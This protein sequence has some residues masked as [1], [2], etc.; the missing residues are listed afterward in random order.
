MARPDWPE[1]RPIA[2][3]VAAWLALAGWKLVLPGIAFAIAHGQGGEPPFEMSPSA[4]AAATAIGYLAY[5]VPGY[6]AARAAAH[7]PLFHALALGAIVAALAFVSG[8]LVGQLSGVPEPVDAGEAL[9]EAAIAVVATQ[10]GGALAVWHMRSRGAGRWG[11]R[12]L[13]LRASIILLAVA[14]VPYALIVAALAL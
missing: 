8:L 9:V 3:G 12:I 1:P 7:K 10:V 5:V 14:L 11:A 2:L 13:S 6:V 4:M